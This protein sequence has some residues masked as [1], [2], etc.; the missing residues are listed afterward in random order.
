MSILGSGRIVFPRASFR[1][2]ERETLQVVSIMAATRVL[3]ADQHPVARRGLRALIRKSNFRVVCEVAH[4]EE[5]LPAAE[6]H[7]V[8]ILVMDLMS[9]PSIGSAVIR[10][11]KERLT[12]PVLVVTAWPGDGVIVESLSAGVDGFTSKARPAHEYQ[13]AL[14]RL[15]AG[16]MVLCPCAE[17]LLVRELLV[18]RARELWGLEHLTSLERQLL[19]DIAAGY[20]SADIARSHGISVRLVETHR[21][22]LRQKLGAHNRAQLVRAALDSGLLSRSGTTPP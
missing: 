14:E 1:Q 4:P 20:S 3:I 2:Y 18:T 6:E 17:R 11:V 15:R 9:T 7:S 16:E 12:L 19:H 8:D 10:Q 21:A 13:F 5:V 22:A